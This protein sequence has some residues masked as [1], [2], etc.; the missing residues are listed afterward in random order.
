[1]TVRPPIGKQQAVPDAVADGHPRRRARDAAGREP[2]RWRLL[3]DLPVDDLGRAI[4]KLDW[5]AQRWK[6]ETYHKVLK[7]GCRAE[8]ARLRTAERLTNLLAVLCV[9]GWRVFWLTMTN[10]ATPEAPAE[11]ALTKAEIEIL[12]RLAGTRDRPGGG[13]CPITSWSP[14]WAATWRRGKDPPPG[15]MVLWRGLTRL[16]DIHLGFEL[17]SQVVGN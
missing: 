6:I 14:S 10:R 9:V 7:S 15:N 5:Y 8:Q 4:E 17:R 11:V 16:M 2:I 1:M 13:R 12:D 3:T